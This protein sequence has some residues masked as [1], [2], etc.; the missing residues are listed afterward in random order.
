MHYLVF[1]DEA[2]A[3]KGQT[4]PEF[5]KRHPFYVRSNVMISMDDYRD[6]QKE[7]QTLNGMYEIPVGEEV[8]WSDLWEKMRKRPR[9]AAATRVREFSLQT[10]SQVRCM[11]TCADPLLRRITMPLQQICTRIILP[12]KFATTLLAMS[13]ASV[14]VRSRPIQHT[15]KSWLRFLQSIM[16]EKSPP[17]TSQVIGG[18]C[19]VYS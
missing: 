18:L 15:A 8:K 16:H 9:T 14:F 19:H 6:F 13:W 7:M 11:V 5:R 2:G 4:T 17:V 12:E 10:M 3:Y 1:T